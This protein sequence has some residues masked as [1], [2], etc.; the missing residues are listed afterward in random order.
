MKLPQTV[1]LDDK[2]KTL[3]IIDQT[4]LPGEL[5]I[6]K[7]STLSE[8]CEAIK[9]LKVRGAPA[10]GVAAALGLYC[11]SERYAESDTGTF[12]TRLAA[13][14]EAL[15]ATRPTA[16]NLSW[17]IGRVTAAAAAAASGG[18]GAVKD[19]V[20]CEALKIRDEDIAVC[21]AIGVNGE[22]LIRSGDAVMTVCNA[23]SLAA[24]ERGTALAPIYEAAERGKAVSVFALETRPLLQGARLTA[25]E[26]TEAGI[27]TTV[28]CDNTAASVMASGRVSAVFTGCDRVAANGD[29]ANKVGTLMLAVLAKHFRIP[30][31]I[32]APYSTIDFDT[33]SGKDIVIE[34]RDGEEV[35]SAMYK[36]PAAAPKAKIYNPAF[37]VTPAELITA[38]VTEKGV[39]SPKNL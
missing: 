28:I 3:D 31:Y 23:G 13:D 2:A 8:M 32:C 39:K 19:A 7:L 5:V 33:K 35:R 9:L 24:V 27:D 10:I 4:R 37:D 6:L 16:K 38:F 14:G 12:L 36:S 25:F 20:R 21:K 1:A 17:A 22:G 26:L 30:F 18:V 29:A 34:E 15:N 11:L